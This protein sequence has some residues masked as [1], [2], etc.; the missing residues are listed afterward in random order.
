MWWGGGGGGGGQK[1]TDMSATLSFFLTPSLVYLILQGDLE[2]SLSGLGSS[3]GLPGKGWRFLF[4]GL[5]AEGSRQLKKRIPEISVTVM[6]YLLPPLDFPKTFNMSKSAK[7]K[8]SIT[9]HFFLQLT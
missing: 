8:I 7:K 1:I 5:G 6:T 9:L 3:L 4:D 2:F